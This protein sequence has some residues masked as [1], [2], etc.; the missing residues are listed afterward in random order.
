[1]TSMP[2]K[3][4]PRAFIGELQAGEIEVVAVHN[5]MFFEEP[6]TIFLHYWG[7][8]GTEALAT[9]FKRALDSQ[10]AAVASRTAV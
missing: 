5:H 7:V 2:T 8:G 4:S 3:M 9:T 1:M 10:G 6:R